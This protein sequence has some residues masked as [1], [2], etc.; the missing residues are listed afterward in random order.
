MTNVH[1]N[2]KFIEI[3]N[4]LK[5]TKIGQGIPFLATAKKALLHTFGQFWKAGARDK[6]IPI[7]SMYH[8][9]IGTNFLTI[10][11]NTKQHIQF[12]DWILGNKELPLKIT[13]FLSVMENKI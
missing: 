11:H 1:K 12:I 2:Y 7:H 8:N 4:I 9:Y 5:S 10:L 3:S 6:I 13:T